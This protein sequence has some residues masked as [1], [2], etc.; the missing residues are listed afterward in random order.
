MADHLWDDVSCF[1]DPDLFGAGLAGGS[2]LDEFCGFLREI[3]R[4]LG[5]PVLMDSEGDYGHPMLGFDVEVDRVA[6]M[7]E[8]LVM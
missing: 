7:A 8:P 4:C 1:F 6:L 5:K 2:R 3:G